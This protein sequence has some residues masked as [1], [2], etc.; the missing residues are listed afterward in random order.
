MLIGTLIASELYAANGGWKLLSVLL[1]SKRSPFP[2]QIERGVIEEQMTLADDRRRDIFSLIM[3]SSGN[4]VSVDQIRIRLPDET[5]PRENSVIYDDL[6]YLMD[7]FY[8]VEAVP[9]KGVRY[10]DAIMF[11]I[12]ITGHQIKS[13]NR[14]IDR[15][16]QTADS[17]EDKDDIMQL[18]NLLDAL[19]TF[20]KKM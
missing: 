9:R 14:A 20:R 19:L 5:R 2:N 7:H 3:E 11:K 13:L 16:K 1:F 4:I 12:P 17:N 15:M 8:P 18:W 10:N 6:N